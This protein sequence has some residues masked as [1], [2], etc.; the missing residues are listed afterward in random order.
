MWFSWKVLLFLLWN[1]Y[2]IRIINLRFLIFKI[3]L[4][5]IS[6]IASAYSNI[7]KLPTPSEVLSIMLGDDMR[8]YRLFFIANENFQQFFYAFSGF[9][10]ISRSL[11]LKIK[12]SNHSFWLTTFKWAPKA[13]A[14]LNF[15]KNKKNWYPPAENPG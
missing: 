4:L 10:L 6:S 5:F 3:L 14:V 9:I 7:N 8:I 11:F 1:K 15:K 2:T 12:K 13:Q